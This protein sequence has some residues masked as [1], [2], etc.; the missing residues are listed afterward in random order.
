MKYRVR[1]VEYEVKQ[2]SI[3]LEKSSMKLN[4]E[5]SS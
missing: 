2:W 1:K 4:S 3:E 5:V